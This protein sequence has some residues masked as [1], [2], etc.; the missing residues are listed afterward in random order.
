MRHRKPT[1]S[2]QAML[3][4]NGEHVTHNT[5]QYD[6]FI[7]VSQIGI[8]NVNLQSPDEN[9]ITVLLKNY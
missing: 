4:K 8:F 1:N 7:N 5:I 9:I 6:K 3:E 2:V